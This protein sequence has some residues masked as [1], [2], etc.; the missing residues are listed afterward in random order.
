MAGSFGKKIHQR[1]FYAKKFR[2]QRNS[3]NHTMMKIFISLPCLIVDHDIEATLLKHTD[4]YV[5]VCLI[6]YQILFQVDK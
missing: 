3:L 5:L 1:L 6:M 4:N 2:K